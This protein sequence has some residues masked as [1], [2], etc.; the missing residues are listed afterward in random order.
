MAKTQ[1]DILEQLQQER[2]SV[3]LLVS[4]RQAGLLADR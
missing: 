2:G 3:P 1:A 4:F